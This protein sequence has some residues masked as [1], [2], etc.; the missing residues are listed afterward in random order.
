MDYPH[1]WSRV[2]DRRELAIWSSRGL[3]GACNY[4][5]LRAAI[6]WLQFS[7]GGIEART[8]F[9]P[10]DKSSGKFFAVKQYVFM[11]NNST[12]H[13]PWIIMGTSMCV[14]LHGYCESDCLVMGSVVSPPP[15]I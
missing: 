2:I 5:N 8:E 9:S 15:I 7:F 13:P 12:F 10:S 14:I 6:R 1:D 4:S 3:D 11:V